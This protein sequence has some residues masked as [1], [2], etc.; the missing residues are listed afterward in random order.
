MR[1]LWVVLCMG[2]Y[3]CE[4]IAMQSRSLSRTH[5]STCIISKTVTCSCMPTSTKKPT[6]QWVT[7]Q[8]Q[9][10]AW[11]RPLKHSKASSKTA[12]RCVCVYEC[13]HEG[14]LVVWRKHYTQRVSIFSHTQTHPSKILRT[15]T[16]TLPTLSGNVHSHAL[17]HIQ[18]HATIPAPQQEEAELEHCCTP[19]QPR[20]WQVD[21]HSHTH[22]HAY[23]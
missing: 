14:V 1:V 20:G 23:Y 4:H 3:V 10:P 12:S 11:P 22:T 7:Q 6:S 17:A 18:E 15:H 16:L 19:H 9:V 8:P 5:R 2:V 21:I 13:V